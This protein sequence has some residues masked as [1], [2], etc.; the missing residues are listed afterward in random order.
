MVVRG[1]DPGDARALGRTEAGRKDRAEDDGDLA[2]DIARVALADDPVDALDRLDRL[3]A[4][5][6][7]GEER[8][9]VALVCGVLAGD[10]GDVGRGPG[11]LVQMVGAQLGEQ[12][13]LR[14]LLRCDHGA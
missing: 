8:P 2:E 11:Q 6:E 10:E 9:P 7:D 12:R 1:L 4:A 14:D 13:D 3:D 5:L